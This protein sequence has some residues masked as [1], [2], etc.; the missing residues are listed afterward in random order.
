MNFQV[1]PEKCDILWTE[2]AVHEF[3]FKQQNH[4]IATKSE[5]FSMSKFVDPQPV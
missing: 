1:K 3:A 2:N 5:D 4:F